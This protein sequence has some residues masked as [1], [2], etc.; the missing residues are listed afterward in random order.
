MVCCDARLARR[1]ASMEDETASPTETEEPPET[2]PRC[3]V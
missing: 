3:S 2:L 1:A